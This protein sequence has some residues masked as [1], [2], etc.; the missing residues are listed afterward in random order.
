MRCAMPARAGCRSCRTSRTRTGEIGLFRRLAKESSRPVTISLLQSHARPDG[1]RDADG[2]DRRGQRR[3][4]RITAQVRS[5]PTSVLLGFE[6]S[7]NP[8][9]GR[10]TYKAIAH[11]PF[12][13]TAGRAA[14]ARVPRAHPQAE[15]FEGSRRANAASSGGTACIPFGDPPDYE[16][17]PESSI[18]ARAAREGRAPEEVAYDLL[19]E[20]DGREMLYL[21]VTNYAARQSRRG[22]RDDRRAQHADRP[23]RRRRACRHH[24]RRHRHQ[25][26][27]DPLDARSRAR[28]VVPGGVGAS[29][30]SPPTT[31]Q[32]IGLCDRGVLRSAR[33]PTSTSSTTTACDCARPEVV[34]DLPAG[35]RRLVQRT[36]GFDATIVSGAVVY[37]HGEAT[38]ALPGRLIRGAQKA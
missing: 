19:L 20:R 37:R 14:Q 23:G 22:A 17:T 11:L 27:A 3:G 16:P 36:D 28:R 26:H 15:A 7:Q 31:P 29:S 6:L 32:A 8:F 34:Y 13:A 12:A 25:L 4:L 30:G 1:W 33:R 38:G 9:M 2:R 35:G 10:P 24:V 18:A 5:R 21:P